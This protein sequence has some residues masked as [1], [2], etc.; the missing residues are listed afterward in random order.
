[1]VSLIRE[2]LGKL[3]ER[4]FDFNGALVTVIDVSVDEKFE[5]AVVKL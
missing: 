4:D 5:Y 1:M 3:L 2:E